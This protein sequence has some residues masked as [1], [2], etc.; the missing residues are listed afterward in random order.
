MTAAAS[1][2]P[3][4]TMVAPIYSPLAIQTVFEL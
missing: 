2:D 4:S 3:F 1:L